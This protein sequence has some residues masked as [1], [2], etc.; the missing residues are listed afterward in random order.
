VK[1]HFQVIQYHSRC[2]I[3]DARTISKLLPGWIIIIPRRI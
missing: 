3:R 2:F 1:V